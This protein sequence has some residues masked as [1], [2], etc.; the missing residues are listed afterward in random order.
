MINNS[1]DNILSEHKELVSLKKNGHGV[2]MELIGKFDRF[3]L[4]GDTKNIAFIRMEAC[5]PILF[6][7]CCC[8]KILSKVSCITL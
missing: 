5:E 6:P 7:S 3:L 4:L 2:A 1:S 8:F